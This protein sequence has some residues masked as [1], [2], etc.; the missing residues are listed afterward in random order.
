M[1]INNGEI[2]SKHLIIDENVQK[3]NVHEYF[4]T[5]TLYVLRRVRAH[6]SYI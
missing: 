2:I 5:E 4:V 1:N 3:I 6:S